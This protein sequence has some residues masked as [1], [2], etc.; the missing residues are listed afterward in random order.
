MA[1]EAERPAHHP[2]SGRC[3]PRHPDP[4]LLLWALWLAVW[5]H[6][7][8]SNEG[9]PEGVPKNGV[10]PPPETPLGRE[11]EASLALLRQRHGG[12]VP[13]H[14]LQPGDVLVYYS[15]NAL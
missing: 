11:R 14:C 12:S 15:C 6:Q 4:S 7:R 2:K 10:L 1:G 9:A 3:N 13:Q 5:A 8:D